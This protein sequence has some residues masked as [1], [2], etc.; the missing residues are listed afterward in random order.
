MLF[1]LNKFYYR[2]FIVQT[3]TITAIEDNFKQNYK[4]Q[5][6]VAW[7]TERKVAFKVKLRFAT[8]IKEFVTF[9]KVA[10]L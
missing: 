5:A 3:L 10:I 2:R 8:F 9:C 4:Y 6:W 1:A 7:F